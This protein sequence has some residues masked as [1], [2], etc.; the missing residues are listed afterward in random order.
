[1]KRNSESEKEIPKDYEIHLNIERAP[2]R[3]EGSKK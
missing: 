2:H 1:M 3:A